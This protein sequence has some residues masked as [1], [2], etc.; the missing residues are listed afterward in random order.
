MRSTAWS[1]FREVYGAT[2][3]I[4]T[5][6]CLLAI[7]ANLVATVVGENAGEDSIATASVE[8]PPDFIAEAIRRTYPEL[9]A[10][11]RVRL[12][13]ESA[14]ALT[15]DPLVQFK[16][17]AVSGTYVNVDPNGFRVGR[18]QGPWPPAAHHFNV[19][20]LGGSTAFG[21]GVPD[22]QT[23]SS[24]LQGILPAVDGRE[25]RVYNFGRGHFASTHERLL[26]EKLALLGPAPDMAIF[27]DGANDLAQPMGTA[28]ASRYLSELTERE[29]RT[30]LLAALRALPLARM[31]QQSPWRVALE[32]Y[33]AVQKAAEEQIEPGTPADDARLDE[34]IRRYL[35][36]KAVIEAIGAAHGVRVVFVWQPV[37]TYK[38]DL[39]QHTYH[40]SFGPHE[41][42]RRGY[43]RMRSC[44]DAHPP[45]AD[46]LWCAD[47]QEGVR[48]LLYVDRMH[49][50]PEMSAR[51]A[52]CIADG[53]E[54]RGLLH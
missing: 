50:S 39:S 44:V 46:F 24:H 29:I 47:I 49:Y 32:R 14:I 17:V 51:V 2:A 3:L 9:S 22:G 41:G 28:A 23:I 10:E 15:R 12:W 6:F 37:P 8:T 16:E 48:K 36:N 11:E 33:A 27:L 7:V 21:Y 18:N 38:Y 43:P 53:I 13:R 30:P 1:R 45:G 4:W 5:N 35:A 52:R 25:V 20:L 19:F 42:S 54:Q 26:F 40:E 31:F 34:L